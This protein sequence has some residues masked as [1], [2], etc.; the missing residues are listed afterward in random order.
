M[1]RFDFSKVDVLLIDPDRGAQE[2]IKMILR[3]EGFRLIRLGTTLSDIGK[4]FKEQMPDV[5]VSECDLGGKGFQKL[6]HQL[7]HHEVGGN[8]FL[9][10]IALTDAPTPEIVRSVMDCGADDIIS[11]PVSTTHLLKRI[12]SRVL[13]RKPFVVTSEYIGPNRRSSKDRPEE[14]PL[15]DV[16]NVLKAKATGEG[17]AEMNAQAIADAIE[18]INIQ[19]LERY[20]IQISWLIE[21]V[22][23]KLQSDVGD[24][25]TEQFL[26]RLLYVS[27]DTSRRMVGTK[28]E[29]VSDL[30]QSLIKVTQ[31]IRDSQLSPD[32]KDV[33][34][35]PEISKAISQGF[36]SAEGT[37]AAARAIAVS[38]GR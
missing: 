33:R 35:L 6:C 1:N 37:A 16:P 2:S 24:Q 11:K 27:E 28:Y 31:N 5:L 15:I 34:L 7:R 30:C 26:N 22:V 20:A 18:E 14:I 8:P 21:R 9:P 10:V 19:K 29:H 23:P 38:I 36:D 13:A 12:E 3:N 17:D 32:I 4:A 25:E